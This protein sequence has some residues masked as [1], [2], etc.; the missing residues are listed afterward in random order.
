MF[1]RARRVINKTNLIHHDEKTWLTDAISSPGR[2]QLFAIQLYQYLYGESAVAAR[3][4]AY[5]RM[6]YDTVRR[7][8]PSPRTSGSSR[9]PTRTCS[10]TRNYEAAALMVGVDID[11]RQTCLEDYER[12]LVLANTLREGLGSLAGTNSCRET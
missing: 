3:F 2:Q 9:T 12:V 7:N 5:V 4:D 8:G 1:E 10:L 6:L 11:D